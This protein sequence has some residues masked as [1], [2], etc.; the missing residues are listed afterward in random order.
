MKHKTLLLIILLLLF[1]LWMCKNRQENSDMSGI[2]LNISKSI[3]PQSNE[4]IQNVAS[5]YANTN[6]QATF[7]NLKITGNINA[8]NSSGQGKYNGLLCDPSNRYCLTVNKVNGEYGIILY[9]TTN[10]SNPKININGNGGAVL[11]N[12]IINSSV[13][14]SSVINSSKIN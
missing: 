13:I 11:T 4:A 3:T 10:W 8:A 1:I 2:N 5:I 9:D 12:S 6:N 14:N 7:N